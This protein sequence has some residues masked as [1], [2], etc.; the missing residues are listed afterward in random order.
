M[1]VVPRSLIVAGGF[2]VGAVGV[3]GAIWFWAFDL[4][5][6]ALR[7]GATKAEEDDMNAPA[8]QSV[9][10]DQF[11][12][13]PLFAPGRRPS[14]SPPVLEA[15]PVAQLPQAPAIAPPVLAGALVG[16]VLSPT[17]NTAIVRLS[18]SKTVAI[19]EGAML[20]DWKLTNVAPDS[21]T[22]VRGSMKTE[23]AFKAPTSAP[24][25]SSAPDPAA[26]T[27]RRGP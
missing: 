27:K 15:A 22:F 9:A 17:E 23:L 21:A 20:G 5:E 7:L 13:R 24:L 2:L 18:E 6:T 8:R 11:V 14:P 12:A 10:L 25:S 3:V 1:S 19:S 4:D 16:V 26:P